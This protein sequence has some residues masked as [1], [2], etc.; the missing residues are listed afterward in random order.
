MSYIHLGVRYDLL[1]VLWKET[2]AC[3]NHEQV[4]K[5]VFKTNGVDVLP[6]AFQRFLEQINLFQI[7]FIGY[8][9]LLLQKKHVKVI[10]CGENGWLNYK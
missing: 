8:I 1:L 6:S 7:D 2:L 10:N 5:R 9:M 3:Q 4:I